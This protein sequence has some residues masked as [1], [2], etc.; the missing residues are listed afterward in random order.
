MNLFVKCSVIGIFVFWLQPITAQTIIWS[1]NFS[2]N[3][4]NDITGDDNNSPAGADW[5]TSCP[6]CNRTN[7]FRV[8]SGEF[9][10]ENT[11]EIATW[12]SET[13]N[14]SGYTNVSITV[15]VD[16]DD[17]QFEA[18]DCITLYYNLDGGGNTQFATNGN[19]CDDGSD[20]TVASQTGLSGTSLVLV[21]EAITTNS[22]EDLHFDNIEVTGELALGEGGPGGI[23]STDGS[24]AL[25][26]WLSANGNSYSDGGSTAA[27]N[28]N[29]VQ[30]WNDLSGNNHHAIETT[31]SEKPT[32]IANSV[33]GY[34]ALD[35]D[36]NTERIAATGLT[37]ASTATVFAVFS[38]DGSG[39]GSNDGV[40][41]ASTS[42]NAFSTAS[43]TKV[44][45]MWVQTSNNVVWGRGVESDG[46]ERSLSQVT[47]LATNQFHIVSQDYDGSDITQY[48]NGSTAGSV[49]YDGT[50]QSWTDFGIGRQGNESLNGQIAEI[51]AYRTHLNTAQRRM[52][53]NYLAAKYDLSLSSNDLYDED[54]T[55]NGNY[56]YEVAGIGQESDGSHEDAQSS[57]AIRILN[58][59]G[60][61]NGE[62]L[63]WGHNNEAVDSWNVT[64]LPGTIQARLARDWSASETGE[65]GTVTV[66]V[67]LSSVAGSITATDLRLLVDDNGVYAAGAT[68]HSGATHLGSDV[69]QWTGIDID[70][71]NH[72]TIGSINSSQTPLPIE[73][74]TFSATP[75][76]EENVVDLFWVTSSEINNDFFTVEKTK[77]LK[78]YEEV[79]QVTGQGT[80]NEETEYHEKDHNPSE[81]VSYY[82]LS[83][84]D[85]DG[86]RTYFDLEK[87]LIDLKQN[88]NDTHIEL[89][90]NPNNGHNMFLKIPNSDSSEI[91]VLVNDFIGKT[92][93]TDFTVINQGDYSVV[94]I[95]MNQKLAA[96]SY[97]INVSVN[98]VNH[99]H[100]LIVR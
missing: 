71:N 12:T 17:N 37:A 76:E 18:T 61:G 34:A 6:T 59:N 82:R 70:N 84:T 14:I 30:Q 15:D 100:K 27:S 43:G 31:N 4:N 87:V 64:D 50:L 38:R 57:G 53:E 21:F 8:E 75:N 67:D 44:I 55:S 93:L 88:E 45:G 95:E 13:I 94:S 58:P 62:Y 63:M 78:T 7:E 60:L 89:Y 54:N 41:H 97:M 91:N 98:G 69:Y 1:E 35:F 86:T 65:V 24:D 90:P 79:V 96:G 49:S 40:I 19:L 81:G 51:I 72:L 3:S 39:G 68:L 29:S 99:S 73:L 10:V 9:R 85:F 77:D 52:V 2:S 83:Q 16:M 22:N 66:Q 92:Y 11:D 80:T 20:P 5:S 48:V 36:G 33:N 23:G 74:K 46:T 26:L 56:D 25:E 28:N 47:A 42:G 32:Y